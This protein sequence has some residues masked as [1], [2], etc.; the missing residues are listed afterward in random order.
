MELLEDALARRNDNVICMGFQNIDA[1]GGD[2]SA[3]QIKGTCSSDLMGS[4]KG[5]SINPT[6]TNNLV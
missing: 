4:N 2:N 6:L 3:I 5:A 1:N